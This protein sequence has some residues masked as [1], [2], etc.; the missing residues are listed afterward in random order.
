MNKRNIQVNNSYHIVGTKKHWRRKQ[1][2]K[3]YI[4]VG[5]G[6]NLMCTYSYARTKSW[7]G[8]SEIGEESE[9]TESQHVTYQRKKETNKQKKQKKQTVNEGKRRGDG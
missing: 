1:Q 5:L 6:A 3:K 2:L 7:R 4:R 8:W 9:Q